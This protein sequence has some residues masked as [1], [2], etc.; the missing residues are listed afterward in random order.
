MNTTIRALRTSVTLP[1]VVAVL[2]AA[3][4]ASPVT[5]DGVQLRSAQRTDLASLLAH[6]VALMDDSDPYRAPTS[7]EQYVGAKAA[8]AEM[9]GSSTEREAAATAAS[10]IG[11]TASNGTDSA[12]GRPY[13]M[14]AS[15]TDTARSWGEVIID[16]S[17]ATRLVIEIPHPKDDLNTWILGLDLYRKVPGSA[18]VVTGATRHAG[19]HSDAAH[20]AD[21]MFQAYAGHLAKAAGKEVQIHGYAN[22]S[23]PNV[24]AIPS[25]GPTTAYA[26]HAAAASKL[27]SD[28]LDVCRGWREYCGDLRG[29]TNVQGK[30]AKARGSRFLHIET[31]KTARE[32]RTNRAKIVNSLAATWN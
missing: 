10:K 30:Y 20:Y 12:T 7:H 31:S 29:T 18:L 1:V 15:E 13:A 5:G 2:V 17:R 6:R 28:S 25:A 32:Y 14:L 16:K 26:A 21:T 27:T 23:L 8:L 11:I 9:S 4:L 3:Y 22:K 19:A 24:D